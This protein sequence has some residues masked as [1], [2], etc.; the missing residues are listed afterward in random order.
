MEDG[1]GG[2]GRRLQESGIT[3]LLVEHDMNLVMQLAEWVIVLNHGRKLV[4]GT[5]A[6]SAAIGVLAA[7][8]GGEP[9]N[10]AYR[11]P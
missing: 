2:V 1:P 7:Y 4:E 11:S 5:A 9:S 3:V 8:L 6:T 10:A